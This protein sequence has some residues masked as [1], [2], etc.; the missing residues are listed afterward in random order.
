MAYNL[1]LYSEFTDY[2]GDTWRI[3][4]YQDNY[5]GSSS[6]FVLGADGFVLRYE[7]DNQSRYQPIIGSSVEIP[8][9]ETL[10]AHTNFIGALATAE[11]G[12]FTVGI[13][14]DPDGA[15]TLYWGGVLLPEQCVFLDE[16]MPRRTS[17][18]AVDDL[19]NLTTILYNN[20]G[21][22]YGDDATVAAHLITALSW[23][24][25][26][27]LW[28][29]STVM[30]KYANDFY[31]VDDVG[32][33]ALTAAKVHH[34]S[35]Y[36]PDDE[37]TNQFLPIYTILETFATTFNARLFQANGT[38]W[39]LPI[40]AYQN[41]TAV[42]FYTVTKAGTV[43]GSPTTLDSVYEVE[44]D[45]KKL[46]GYEHT[47]LPP[48]YKVLRTQNYSGNI[49]RIFRNLTVANFTTTLT[50]AD[51]DYAANSVFR[52][53][54]TLR[55]TQ[56]G[57]NTTTGNTRLR[58]FRLRLTLKV[59]DYY[60]KRV[61]TFSG[62]AS[63]F[64]TQ[65]GTV[66][67]YT[68]HTYGATSW[69]LTAS[70]YDII[71]P[72]YD[73]NRGLTGD[74]TLVM[75]LNFLTPE[76]TADSNSIESTMAI[77][78]VSNT[79][80][81]TS[82]TNPNTNYTIQLYRLD[83][84]EE[85]A[86]NGDLVTYSAT[87]LDSSRVEYE[88]AQVWVGDGVSLNSLG[89]I[90][91][92]TGSSLDPSTGW[93]SLNYSGTGIGIHLLGVREVLG[94]QRTHT[95]V[96]RGTFKGGIVEM[97]HTLDDDGSYYL[98]FNLTFYANARQTEVESFFIGRDLT[99][100]T[101]DESGRKNINP[102]V[103]GYPGS[104]D[105]GLMHS[106]T[107]AMANAE[108]VGEDLDDL[109]ATVTGISSK[110]ELL[111]ETFRPKGDDYV[112]TTITYE[113]DKLDGG[114]IE[115]DGNSVAMLS[116][117]GNSVISLSESSPGEFRVDLQD[118][119]TPTPLS[120][121][122]MFATA[123]KN[124]SGLV[125]LGTEAP[126]ER[127]H[128][129]GNAKVQGNIIVSGTVDGVD[130]AT[131]DARALRDIP[132]YNAGTLIAKGSIVREDGAIIDTSGAILKIAPFLPTFSGGT[133]ILPHRILGVTTED[134]GF[135]GLGFVRPLGVVGGL[136]TNA[137]TVGTLLYAST[138]TAGAFTNAAPSTTAYYEQIIGWVVRQSATVGEIFV[139]IDPKQFGAPP[140]A[141]TPPP[142]GYS[143][144]FFQDS[145]GSQTYDS[146]F[147]YAD[148]TNTLTIGGTTTTA[149]VLRL[150]E[151]S[152]NG[153]NS[154]GIQA[155]TTLSADTTYTL[156]SADGTTGQVLS[157]NASGTL[158]W[159]TRKATQVTG[160]TV[161]TGAWSL[162][163]GFYEA[164]ISDSAIL[165]TSIVDVIPDNASASVAATAGVL[166]RTDSSTGAVKIYATATPAST[167]TV[168]LNI[169]DL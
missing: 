56:P 15:N 135:R 35:F 14:R 96:Q 138:T 22:G 157:T 123:D 36:N 1:R 75:P 154:I 21:T 113:N 151:A 48:L 93:Q 128:V 168:T 47:Y 17:L 79:G 26:S 90:R 60:L 13:F 156:P 49:P 82:V 63:D 29:S 34:N 74:T 31:S 142:G 10:S 127:L 137:Y 101:S 52:I 131:L 121:N 46:R 122:V 12:E 37:G 130:V 81:I 32:T 85:D 62:A 110:V 143:S 163:S 51:F 141:G 160:K 68:P 8:F 103:D 112:K 3:N 169:F 55:V 144:V 59:G 71:T 45:G 23:V 33:N 50:D 70:T 24:R 9:T 73:I 118:D 28:T 41:S 140:I 146:S 148:A 129:V 84:V 99:D 83:Q 30:L 7:G 19:G 97:F 125:G 104:P 94:G 72:T 53:S 38:Y 119:T 108:Q 80:A 162:V 145:S 132:V 91:I 20:A 64:H 161:G 149:G 43:S 107:Q 39:F 87:G 124:K 98:P 100:I 57:D 114:T 136:N 106:F 105:S 166:P 16:A 95:K 5:G 133:P 116:G 78:N 40:G 150:G 158:S 54:G 89:V 152:N 164:S 67:T 102:P 11:E 66:L 147:T 111:F 165:S 18:K 134:I 4:I 153:T 139:R 25:H 44:V 115:L 167:L 86:T 109:D 117:T 58:R 42:D 77:A 2:E 6:A 76:L 61:A 159:A 120:I 65:V 69:E 27:H 88:Q 126:E 92:D 155:P